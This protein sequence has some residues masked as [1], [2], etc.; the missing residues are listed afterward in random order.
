VKTVREFRDELVGRVRAL[1]LLVSCVLVLV[2]TGFWFVQLVQGGY[3]AELADNNRLRKLPI[4]APRGLIFD[5]HGRSLVEN[6]PS[7]SLLLDRSRTADVEA[8]LDYAA[9]VLG[10]PRERLDE[11]LAR[12][13]GQAS[14]VPVPVARNLTLAQVAEFSVVALEHPEFEI[15]VRH[16]RLYRHGVQTAHVLGYI[17]EASESDL[18]SGGYRQGDLVGREGVEQTYDRD[19]R[20]TSGERVVVVDSRGKTLEE[21]QRIAAHPGTNLKLTLD[22]DL[23]QEAERLMRD[24]TGAVVALDPRDGEVLALV[25]SPSYNPNQ[26]ARGLDAA[27]WQA[28]LDDPGKPLQDRAI[29]NAHSPGSVFKMV[30]ASAGLAE[31]VIDGRERVFCRG[32]TTLYGH[33]FGCWRAGGHGWVDLHTA[34][35][36][37]CNVY[38]YHLGQKLGIERIAAYARAFGL[39]SPTGIDLR[40][41][42]AGLVPD[43][44]WSRQVRRSP[45]FP[46]ETISVAIGQGSMLATPLQ[47]AR[48]V[49]AV[50]NGGRLVHPHLVRSLNADVDDRIPVPA[51]ALAAV[52]E[53]LTAVVN[54]PT[55]TAY[56]VAHLADVAIAGKTGTVQVVARSAVPNDSLPFAL[57]NH[58]WFASFAPADDPRLV[59]VVFVEHGGAGSSG[60]A[61]IAKS[62]YETYFHADPDSESA[63]RL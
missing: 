40:G 38:F 57:R 20:G 27:E 5:R 59:V 51:A 43:P 12:A 10:R 31:G 24:R 47:I 30:M 2:G 63:R 8:S 62:L 15:D 49:A 36:R 19:L 35:E 29:H 41:E 39:G 23:Q 11:E 9:T 56:A 1:S 53:G 17:G 14:F 45:W 54:D 28:L 46:G 44:D 4:R 32:S 13:H 33:T 48:M 7:Y 34:I 3:Y 21:H 58:A 18:E 52:R 60:A 16:L 22:L 25:S 42:K 61:P 55:G 50:A 37:S 6:I 26:F